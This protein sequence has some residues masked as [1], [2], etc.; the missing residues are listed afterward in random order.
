MLSKDCFTV[1][2]A[3]DLNEG[4]ETTEKIVSKFRFPNARNSGKRTTAAIATEYI[5]SDLP[6][7]NYLFPRFNQL[8]EINIG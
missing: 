4:D 5:V 3:I 2:P 7:V 8:G 1:N 6:F